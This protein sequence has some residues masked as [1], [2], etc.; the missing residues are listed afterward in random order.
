MLEE[1][2]E[3]VLVSQNLKIAS[4]G[5]PQAPNGSFR[6]LFSPT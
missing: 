2:D 4:S 1:K 3:N 6:S 5:V